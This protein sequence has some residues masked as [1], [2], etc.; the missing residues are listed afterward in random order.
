MITDQDDGTAGKGIL[1]CFALSKKNHPLKLL[2]ALGSH[3]RK[4][5]LEYDEEEYTYEMLQSLSPA[6]IYPFS[7]TTLFSI[8]RLQ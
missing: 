2:L 1:L 6:Y 8:P 7:K 5:S 4:M 3:E